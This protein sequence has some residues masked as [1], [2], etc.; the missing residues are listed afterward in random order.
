[1]IAWFGP[2]ALSTLLLI[3]LPVFAGVPQSGYL[4]QVCCVVVLFSVVIHG[5]SPSFLRGA[6][7]LE[8]K[9]KT[10]LPPVLAPKEPD[11]ETASLTPE[12][13][14]I[15][16]VRELEKAPGRVVV[17]DSRSERTYEESDEEIPGALRLHPDRAAAQARSYG[18]SKDSVLAVICA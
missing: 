17:I 8:P 9:P 14:T 15:E 11:G 12:F 7:S 6:G 3:L 16:E 2:R 13:I 1:M 10:Q 5:L 4:L 18:V